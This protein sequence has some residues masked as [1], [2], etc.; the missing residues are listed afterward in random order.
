MRNDALSPVSR[1]AAAAIAVGVFVFTAGGQ[2]EKAPQAAG[3]PTEPARKRM[4]ERHL[5][6]N[7]IKDPRVLEAFRNVPRHRFVP[8]E[9]QRLAYDNESLPIGEKQTITP[10]FDVAFMTEALGPKPTDR[11]FEVGTGS[12]YQA[13]ILSRLVKEVYS[14]EIHEPLA[15]RAAKTL[16][17]LGYRNVHTRHGDGYA[18]WPEAAPF[19][20]VIVTCAPRNVPK[21]LVE[22]LRE[23]GRIVIPIAENRYKQSL[24]ILE[25][26]GGE[27]VGRQVLPTLFVPMTGKAQEGAEGIEPGKAKS[28]AKANQAD[29]EKPAAKPKRP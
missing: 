5:V 23:G 21:P 10:V 6:E 13:A 19:D 20:A 1:R 26:K 9:Y 28:G 27:L 22:Q 8:A 7:G 3:D 24:W 17:D 12:G 18:G 4:V 29:E 2:A 25:K 14:V 11:V 16:E 15:Q